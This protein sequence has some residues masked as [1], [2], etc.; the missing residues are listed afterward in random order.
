MLSTLDS[1]AYEFD[2][3]SHESLSEMGLII[4]QA[5]TAIKNAFKPKHI[6]VSKYGVEPGNVIHFHIIP[7]YDWIDEMIAADEN[8]SFIETLYDPNLPMKYDAADYLLFIWR[9][10]TEKAHQSGIDPVN[11]DESIQIL[12][13]CLS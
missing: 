12:K 4:E 7:I 3:L 2:Q 10:L 6:F 1:N 9:E 8:Y 13:N 11:I 5:V